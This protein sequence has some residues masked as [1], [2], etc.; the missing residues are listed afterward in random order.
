MRRTT[1]LIVGGGPAGCAAAITLARG[2]SLA[3]V[4]DRAAV[5][6]PVCGAFVSWDALAA[7]DA[8]GIDVWRLG[9]RRITGVRILAGGRVVEQALPAVAAGISRGSLDAAL[10]TQAERSGATLVSANARRVEGDRVVLDDGAVLHSDSL[11][12]ATG[13]HA[14]RGVER[15]GRERSVH[16]GFRAEIAAPPELDGWIELH[17]FDSGYAGLLMQED[18][19]ANLCLSVRQ[20]RLKQAGSLPRLLEILAQQSPQ[21]AA[22]LAGA[23]FWSAIAGVPYGRIVSAAPD[24]RFR[25]GDQASV[26]ASVVGDGI[27]IALASGRSAGAAYLNGGGAA[28]SA[29]Q[30]NWAARARRPIRTAEALR[31]VAEQPQL[32][33]LAL[34]GFAA[35]PSALSLASRITRIGA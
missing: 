5:Q 21:L 35:L 33:A 31:H 4:V 6:P 30:R 26:I 28:A 1:P 16:V 8:L 9:A 25:I 15:S 23:R 34:R 3:T 18:G 13:K 11:F 27:A 14:L 10:R 32:A 12:V 2:G 22:A 7:L 24:G 29:F 17:L 19:A 20:A